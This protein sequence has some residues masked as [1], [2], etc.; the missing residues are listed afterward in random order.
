VTA[1]TGVAFVLMLAA[2]ALVPQA[3][4]ERRAGEVA[5]GDGAATDGTVRK[6]RQGFELKLP[7]GWEVA[8]DSL[9]QPGFEGSM[10]L[11]PVGWPLPTKKER[12]RGVP[13]RIALAM[14]LYEPQTYP[15]RPTV[16]PRAVPAE[17]GTAS[18][19]SDDRSAPRPGTRPDG[20]AYLVLDQSSGGGDGSVSYVIAWPYHCAAGARCSDVAGYRVISMSGHW[21]SEQGR[22][23]VRQVVEPLVQTI[24]PIGNA[25]PGGAPR[26]EIPDLPFTAPVQVSTAVSG[27]V[28]WTVSAQWHD[29][30]VPMSVSAQPRTFRSVFARF[31]PEGDVR[32]TVVGTA[33]ASVARMVSTPE[34]EQRSEQKLWAR[35]VC[36]GP[37]SAP[38]SWIPALVGVADDEAVSVRFERRDGPPVSAQ[39]VG[40]DSGFGVGFFV[41]PELPRDTEV[42]RLQAL[43]AAGRV[44]G[45]ITRYDG[46]D[47]LCAGREVV[48]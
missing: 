6:P 16:D 8:E 35:G 33:A 17:F 9:D 48:R 30:G 43:D 22:A 5:A 25:L 37:D 41:S 45:E 26:D 18:V 11:R 23:M 44:I 7:S 46:Y 27:T 2:A 21:S 20:R 10:I 15:G 32:P 39:V 19:L 4:S 34:A 40:K 42:P 29:L 1:L 47:R 38:G 36:L 28:H 24:R 12:G 13:P 3:L 14:W 31:Q